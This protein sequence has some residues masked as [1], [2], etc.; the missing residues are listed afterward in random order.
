MTTVPEQV[1]VLAEPFE[2]HAAAYCT[3]VESS[4]CDRTTRQWDKYFTSLITSTRLVGTSLRRYFCARPFLRVLARLR[5]IPRHF[6]EL[7]LEPAPG[8]PIH[9]SP[10]I[11]P[12]RNF[13]TS[14]RLSGTRSRDTAELE[15]FDWRSIREGLARRCP[16]VLRLP[17][18]L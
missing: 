2:R 9:P 7:D 12:F 4:P 18:H 17:R 10:S 11:I 1:R 6:F 13:S 5:E 15:T 14:S 8:D 16:A 3:T